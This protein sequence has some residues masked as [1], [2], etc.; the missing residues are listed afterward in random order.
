MDTAHLVGTDHVSY[1]FYLP[2]HLLRMV[3]DMS[4]DQDGDSLQTIQHTQTTLRSMS[5]TLPHKINLY[6]LTE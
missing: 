1:G 4:L 6:N 2:A 3:S 5:F